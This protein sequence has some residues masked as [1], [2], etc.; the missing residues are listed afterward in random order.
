MI[1]ICFVGNLSSTFIKRDYEILKKH[2][3]V[4]AVEPPKEKAKWC[5]YISIIKKMV[6]NSDISFSWFAGWHSAPAVYYSK[7]YNRKK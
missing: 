1:K 6:K 4:Y 2:F 5:R 7:K 3:D